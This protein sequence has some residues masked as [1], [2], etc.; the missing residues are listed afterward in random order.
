MLHTLC[1]FLPYINMNQPQAYVRPLP[2]KPPPTS[3][4]IPCLQAVTEHRQSCFFFKDS[5]FMELE[6]NWTLATEEHL[7]KSPAGHSYVCHLHP[8]YLSYPPQPC[9]CKPAALPPLPARARARGVAE[10]GHLSRPQAWPSS[11]VLCTSPASLGPES[12][13]APST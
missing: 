13:Q 11:W 3:L 10:L 7:I 12:S 6:F 4:P 2:L 1:W 9:P 5:I 8:R